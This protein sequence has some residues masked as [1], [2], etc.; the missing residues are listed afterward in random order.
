MLD[1]PDLIIKV[2]SDIHLSQFS[3]SIPW[4]LA[5]A[6]IALGYVCNYR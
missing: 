5:P 1:K 2:D 4:F 3:Q 6:N